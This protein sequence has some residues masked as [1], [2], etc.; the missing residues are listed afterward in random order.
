MLKGFDKVL[1]EDKD[2]D[3]ERIVEL[4]KFSRPGDSLLFPTNGGNEHFD[5]SEVRGDKLI[6]DYRYFDGRKEGRTFSF[7]EIA[8]MNPRPKIA[9]YRPI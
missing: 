4:L 3:L 1:A 8:A 9:P 5:I 6:G 7:E 2:K